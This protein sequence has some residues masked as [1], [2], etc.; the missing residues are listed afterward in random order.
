MAVDM[1]FAAKN[2]P[3]KRVA[4][5][6]AVPAAPEKTLKEIRTEGL[7]GIGETFQGL[8]VLGGQFAD[9]GAI[10][11]HWPRIAEETAGLADAYE[12]VAK[13]VDILISVTPIA[14]LL[15]AVL[16]LALQIGVNH[17]RI[18]PN[19]MMGSSVVPPEVLESQMK[20]RI[21]KLQADAQREHM[22]A[23]REAQAA[24]AEYEA[25]MTE[26]SKEN[27]GDNAAAMAV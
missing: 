6:L 16:P 27:V 19:A 24:Q 4:K 3:R 23:L 20:A 21:M 9:A 26:G 8:C 14:G 18:S 5:A 2:P 12:I 15:A 17:R 25:M 10:G 22:E 11:M 13:P 7:A 1:S